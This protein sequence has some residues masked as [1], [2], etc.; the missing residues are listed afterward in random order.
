MAYSVIEGFGIKTQWPTF[1]GW[2]PSLSVLRS[3]WKPS[4][5]APGNPRYSLSPACPSPSY[6]LGGK[7]GY[8]WV[9]SEARDPHRRWGWGWGLR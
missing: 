1:P 9:G 2:L 8:P 3:L 4:E 5:K 6:Q 7:T